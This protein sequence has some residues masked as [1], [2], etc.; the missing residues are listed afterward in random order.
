MDTLAAA[1]QALPAPGDAYRPGFVDPTAYARA[2]ADGHSTLELAV[3]GAH[4][5]GCLRKIESGLAKLPGVTQARLNLTTKKLTVS[6]TTGLQ[7]PAGIARAL[8]DLGFHSVPYDAGAEADHQRASERFLL[9]CLAV[10]GAASMNVMLFSISLWSGGDEMGAG[11]RGLLTW[12]SAL[13]ALPAIAFAGRPF[14]RSAW[15]ALRVRQV[16]MDVP[17]S[18]AVGLAVALSLFEALGGGGDTYFEAAIMLVFLL[19][20]GRYLDLRL[21]GQARSAAR[22]LAALQVA[23]ASR[24]DE[25]GVIVA[26][27]VREIAPGDRVLVGL[28]EQVPVNGVIEDGLSTLDVSLI[29]GETAPVESG[30]GAAVYSGTVNLSRAIVVRATAA[31]GDSLLAEITR[32]VEAGEQARSRYVK[33]ADRAAALYVPLVHSLS[34]AT[35]VGWLVFS[36]AGLHGALVHAIAVLIITCPCALGLAVPAVQVVATGRLF[37]RGVL[38]KTGDALERLAEIDVVVFDKT[39]TLTAPDSLTLER[40]EYTPADLQCAAMVARASRH[41]LARALAAAAGPGPAAAD[42]HEVPGYGVEAS[43]DGARVR[44]GA[45]AWCGAPEGGVGA[46][47]Q[48]W[49]AVAER[50]P[51]RFSFT[52]QV[53]PDARETVAALARQGLE[54][55]LLS[56][57]RPACVEAVAREVAI[58]NWAAGLTPADKNARLIALRDQGRRV[59]MVGDG[60]NDAPALAA[61]HVSIAPANAIDASQAA[62]DLVLQGAS[63]APIVETLEVARI[64]KRRALENLGFSAFYN[65]CAIPLAV[66]GIVTPLIA[67][68]AMSASSLIVTLNALRLASRKPGP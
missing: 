34:A 60:L 44:L 57:D 62:S 67:A 6:W 7:S 27:P 11:T 29:T 66:V 33:L 13:I 47:A 23:V 48:L 32:L 31:R 63:L 24:I 56:G 53:R 59:L 42:V 38:V 17:I 14:F 22:R 61:A 18:L 30:P 20:I 55:M 45:P 64:A 28:G 5:A 8:H 58:S 1:A 10:A 2:G 51:V 52:D 35:F 26:V 43:V 3:R 25:A 46:T 9:R 36:N 19:L 40:G 50:P 68:V 49:L 12:L 15:R 16:N 37:E 39:G 65:A 4:C 54:I 21:R 41:P